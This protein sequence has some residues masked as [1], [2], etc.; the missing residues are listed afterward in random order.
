[1]PKWTNNLALPDPF[2]RFVES[3][4]ERAG[5]SVTSLIGPAWQRSL[6]NKHR[7]EIVQDVSDSVWALFGT[8]VHSL[9]ERYSSDSELVEERI[10]IQIDGEVITG[11]P[12]ILAIDSGILSDWKVCS[13]WALVLGDKPDWCAQLNLYAYGLRQAGKT[14]TQIQ[15]VCFIRDWSR[16]KA[17]AGD[18]YPQSMV[19]TVQHDLWSDADCEAFLRA[20]LSEHA[21]PTPCTP[22]E[23][24][25]RPTTFAV[26]AEG[27]VRAK[28]VLDTREA[29]EAW[30]AENKGK[31]SVVE[32]PGEC[33]RCESYCPVAQFCEVRNG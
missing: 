7:A 1:M 33:V 10:Q 14:V 28:R 8:A 16:N 11:Q 5:L 31:L 3:Q 9:L 27:Q 25:A 21:N 23:R 2:V 4:P 18:G 15:N 19:V 24:W 13:A 30:A 26:M 32:R 20:R 22:D 12:D 17:K 29:A 6:I